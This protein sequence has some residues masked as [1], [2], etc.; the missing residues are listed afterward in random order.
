MKIANHL[1]VDAQGRYLTKFEQLLYQHKNLLTN[2][3]LSISQEI[4][5]NET[6]ILKDASA[7]ILSLLQ[8][9]GVEISVNSKRFR[10]ILE[11]NS[12]I[13]RYIAT[14]V[15]EGFRESLAEKILAPIVSRI[16]GEEKQIQHLENQ[17][18]F[19]LESIK[20]NLT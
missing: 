19:L 10:E 16:D 18:Y 14:T 2:M 11:E 6:V 17:I 9:E 4:C 15:R 5:V 12:N 13:L 7:Y 3:S 1:F 8:K 20:D